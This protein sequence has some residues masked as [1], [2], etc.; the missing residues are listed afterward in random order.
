M[1]VEAGCPQP[2]L[3]GSRI[4]L[5]IW[6]TLRPKTIHIFRFIPVMHPW[7]LAGPKPKGPRAH[8][9][10][11]RINLEIWYT[12]RPKGLHIFRFI[13][14]MHPW[15][16]AATP[17]SPPPPILQLHLATNKLLALKTP[18]SLNKHK[19]FPSSIL[20]LISCDRLSHQNRSINTSECCRQDA[21]AGHSSGTAE[22][23]RVTRKRELCQREP[24]GKHQNG[25]LP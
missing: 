13:P 2:H 4:N 20:L 19:Y 6:Y 22:A 25:K 9:A 11:S 17:P 8:R 12:L 15:A 7:A 5:K 1:S 3:P 14:G 24:K 18:D 23:S 10:G 16:L 21:S